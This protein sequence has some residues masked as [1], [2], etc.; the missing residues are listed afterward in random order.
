MTR[1]LDRL[2]DDG[3]DPIRCLP[4]KLVPPLRTPGL[5]QM[6]LAKRVQQAVDELATTVRQMQQPAF[7]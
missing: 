1:Q 6:A 4:R 7:S 5:T 2:R 3:T